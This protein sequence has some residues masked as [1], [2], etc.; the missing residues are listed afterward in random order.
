[1]RGDLAQAERR[2][3]GLQLDDRAC[4]IPSG[5]RRRSGRRRCQLRS[6]RL[7]M[8]VA[9]KRATLR[10]RVRSGTPVSRARAAARLAEEHDRP[11]Q[12]V[13]FLLGRGDEQAEL[14]PVVGGLAAR[15][16]TGRHRPSPGRTRS[17][18]RA[19]ARRGDGPYLPRRCRPV[20]GPLGPGTGTAGRLKPAF[21]EEVSSGRGYVPAMRRWSVRRCAGAIAKGRG[22]TGAL[23]DLEQYIISDSWD[24][25]CLA[26]PSVAR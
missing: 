13:G 3:L 26:R 12:F 19:G 8:P 11:Q 15:S 6:N 17:P 1:M 7:R 9:S 21:D 2:V 22:T 16:R 25:I 5:S 18:R 23:V 24:R 4:R 10:R 20:N 14:L